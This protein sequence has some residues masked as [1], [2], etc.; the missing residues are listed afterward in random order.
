LQ[1][2]QWAKLI[3]IRID[4]FDC[5]RKGWILENFPETRTQSIALLSAGVLPKHTSKKNFSHHF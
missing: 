4:E 3:K 2:N 5:V 1:P